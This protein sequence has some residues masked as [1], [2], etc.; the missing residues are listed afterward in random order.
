MSATASTTCSVCSHTS[1]P[2]CGLCRQPRSGPISGSTT[3]SAPS[4]SASRSASAG[5]LPPTIRRSSM[6]IRSPAGSRRQRRL[7]N[8]Q[9]L[10]GG[11][12][13][14]AE[15]MRDPR[16][17]Q[18]PQRVVAE[19][20]L[21]RR[22]QQPPAE[23][24][25]A[26]QRVDHRAVV[27]RHRD[28]IDGEVAQGQVVLDAATAGRD[29]DRAALSHHPP[30]AVA[31]RQRKRRSTA[32]AG[33][34][35]GD[36]AR[37]ALHHQV[38]VGDRAAEQQVADAAAHQPGALDR[39]RPTAPVPDGQRPTTTCSTRRRRGAMSHTIS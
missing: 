24:V 12:D 32:V 39:R 35:P 16:Q 11:I 9:P 14:E 31:F 23:V 29:V 21:G 6:K 36:L 18:Q 19:G 10:G 3:S 5:R 8:G 20:R 38:D 30:G 33:H 28:R 37:V 22:P 17:P 13:L 26:G 7:G 34:P 1:K 15:L 27:E 2:W 4:R 25:A